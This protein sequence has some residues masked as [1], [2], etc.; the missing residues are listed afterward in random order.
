MS[1]RNQIY[2]NGPAG[3]V[4][5]IRELPDG[6]VRGVAIVTH[7]H[8]LLGGTA[9]HKVPYTIAQVCLAHGLV[10]LRPNFRGV[11]GTA[12]LH[13]GG[14]GEADDIQ[15]IARQ[16][17]ADYDGLPLILAGFSFGAFVQTMVGR[18]LLEEGGQPVQM[19]LA[20]LPYGKIP[21]GR[22]YETPG[23]PES[24]LVIHGER[25][26]VV[27]LA[28]V[29]EWLRPQEIPVVVV[30]GAGHFFTGKLQLLRNVLD[31]HLRAW[32]PPG[33]GECRVGGRT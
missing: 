24:A 32:F 22:Q 30:P 11:G 21:A 13:D 18:R 27:P 10:A 20:G 26:E 1:T 14:R 29:F 19:I 31:D 28:N 33:Y 8:P 9:E 12:G 3:P 5:I 16:A 23:V 25:D 6:R 4:E 15:A 7:P 17:M 2:F